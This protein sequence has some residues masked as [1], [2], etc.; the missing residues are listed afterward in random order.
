MKATRIL[1]ASL[2]LTACDPEPTGATAEESGTEPVGKAD[3]NDASGAA[4]AEGVGRVV[5][6]SPRS[7]DVVADVFGA[8]V[9]TLIAFD[10]ATADA[11]PLRQWRDAALA[12]GTALMVRGL[13]VDVD[14]RETP[15]SSP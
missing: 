6:D 3:A 12:D 7:A 14:P 9:E 8:D 5:F 1:V 4:F 2:A 11:D 10:E 13:R 15:R